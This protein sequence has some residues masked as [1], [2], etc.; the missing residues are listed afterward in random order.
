MLVEVSRPRHLVALVR[1]PGTRLACSVAESAR[2]RAIRG[3]VA[4]PPEVLA[5]SATSETCVSPHW[6]AK[7]AR[8]PELSAGGVRRDLLTAS[9]DGSSVRRWPSRT[10]FSCRLR[11]LPEGA[12]ATVSER[13]PVCVCAGQGGQCG[14]CVGAPCGYRATGRPWGIGRRVRIRISLCGRT[15]ARVSIRW[16]IEPV[17]A[18]FRPHWQA[19]PC[20]RPRAK[21]PPEASPHH[22]ILLDVAMQLL[23]TSKTS[24]ARQRGRARSAAI[25]PFR[26]CIHETWLYPD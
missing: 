26:R 23:Y 7:Q 9:T 18:S 5:T 17:Y 20:T 19:V 1:R 21:G 4:G 3:P 8:R 10:R 13:C 22:H 2:I 16:S 25:V 14:E 12:C 15:L 24:F 6:H 11:V